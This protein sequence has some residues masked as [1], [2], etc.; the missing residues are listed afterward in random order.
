[1]WVHVGRKS[2]WRRE[3]KR[4][5]KIEHDWRSK[6]RLRYKKVIIEK[7]NLITTNGEKI[8][9]RI[10]EIGRGAPTKNISRGNPT[11]NNIGRVKISEKHQFC[12]KT[13]PL[14]KIFL[15][16]GNRAFDKKFLEFL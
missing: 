15:G 11:K 16:R 8:S 10:V 1:L 9:Q 4:A 13:Q 2:A 5:L 7:N 12:T 3:D 6:K 14:P